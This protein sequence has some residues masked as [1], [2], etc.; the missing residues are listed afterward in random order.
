MF[1]L[2]LCPGYYKEGERS[3][4]GNMFQLLKEAEAW[5]SST[6]QVISILLFPLV[7]HITLVS[8]GRRRGAMRRRRNLTFTSFDD[9]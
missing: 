9:E 2:H 8:C 5:R 6:L 1:A 4:E 7:I 3:T